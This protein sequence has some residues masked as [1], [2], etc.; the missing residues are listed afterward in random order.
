MHPF[1]KGSGRRGAV[2]LQDVDR[3]QSAGAQVRNRCSWHGMPRVLPRR[4]GSVKA[5]C[6]RRRPRSFL[7]RFATLH[8]A[9]MIGKT[10]PQAARA[11]VQD[12]GPSPTLPRARGRR[13]EASKEGTR[14]SVCT[15]SAASAMAVSGPVCSPMANAKRISPRRVYVLNGC[16]KLRA[17]YLDVASFEWPAHQKPFRELLRSAGRVRT[18]DARTYADASP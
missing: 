8:F 3:S 16:S 14:E 1:V 7:L 4:I 12:V 2:F 15:G 10:C 11:K 5:G 18:T 13:T 6:T 9:R 17:G